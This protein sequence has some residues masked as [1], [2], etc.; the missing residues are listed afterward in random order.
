MGSLQVPAPKGR[1]TM[2]L[3]DQAPQRGPKAKAT[4]TQDRLIRT[5]VISGL[6]EAFR[7]I[8]I[9]KLGVEQFCRLRGVSGDICISNLTHSSKGDWSL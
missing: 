7:Q 5:E 4:H 2:P 9:E 1:Q 8:F 3:P 6:P